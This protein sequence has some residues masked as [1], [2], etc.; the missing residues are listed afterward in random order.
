MERNLSCGPIYYEFMPN[1]SKKYREDLCTV[2][3]SVLFWSLEQNI[4]EPPEAGVTLP[5]PCP[6]RAQAVPLAV[7]PP[8]EHWRGRTMGSVRSC[9]CWISPP[10]R[11]QVW[12]LWPEQIPWLS[13]RPPHLQCPDG[14]PLGPLP[15]F[16]YALASVPF[17]PF[18][19]SMMWT[20]GYLSD[21]LS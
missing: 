4:A 18:R 13:P 7:G 21:L 17:L 11:A 19:Y 2:K 12:P 15:A 5:R 9:S 8:Q 10:S 16:C 1:M 14:L 6:G 3:K 20:S